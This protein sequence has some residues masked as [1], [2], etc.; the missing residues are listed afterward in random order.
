MNR[1]IAG[2]IVHKISSRWFSSAVRAVCLDS[3]TTVKPYPTKEVTRTPTII[4]KSWRWI[5]SL[6]NAVPGSDRPI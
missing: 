1:I 2:I 5:S 6:I 3:V 4:A